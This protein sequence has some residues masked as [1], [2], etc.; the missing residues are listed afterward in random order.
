MMYFHIQ[1]LLKYS[2][3][4]RLIM[5]IYKIVFP[6]CRSHYLLTTN[7]FRMGGACGAYGGGERCAQDFGGEA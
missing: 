7:T 2:L 4:N 1:N 3:N 6:V 5:T